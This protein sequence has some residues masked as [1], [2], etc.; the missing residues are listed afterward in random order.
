MIAALGD[1]D[2]AEDAVQ[3]A[4]AVALERW[5]R[6][7]VPANPG[8][9]ITTVARNKA[10]DRL[11]REANLGR[12]RQALQALAELG[13]SHGEAADS[14]IADPDPYPDERLR[15]IFTCCH[16]ALAAQS[17][18]ALTLR[19]LGGLTTA[20]IARA[21][22]TTESAMS[23][24]LVR[25]KRKI[26]A[27][28]IAYE[29]PSAERMPARLPSV[30]ATIYLIFNEGY[31]GTASEELLREDLCLEA[32]RLGSLLATT[33]DGD[34]EAVGLLALMELTHARRRA[35]VGA[36]GELVRLAEQ[37]RSLWDRAQIE[38]GLRLGQRACAPGPGGPYTVQAAIAMV[39][40]GAATAEETDWARIANLY[41][42]LASFDPSPVVEL[43]RA[44][45]VA[46]TEGPERGLEIIEAISGLEAYQPFH[47]ARAELLSRL[48][49]SR[50]ARDAYRRALALTKNPVQRSFLERRAA[51]LG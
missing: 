27:A 13:P 1:F 48:D 16:P 7:G 35:R 21:F 5:P 31:L 22:L 24:R 2:L 34:Q 20:E 15:L 18:V 33:L 23:Q 12:K 37:D 14:A 26:R 19:T 36:A 10:L 30:L 3:E 51:R 49:R 50:E 4:F 42:W 29:V 9:W 39:H 41:A 8:A 11:R 6:D 47:V 38:R 45:A 32:I 46:E 44:V 17:R 43:N 28:G 25:A 40:A